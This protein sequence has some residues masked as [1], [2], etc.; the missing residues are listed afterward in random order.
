MKRLTEGDVELIFI[1]T[2]LAV[3]IFSVFSHHLDTLASI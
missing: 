2:F 1:M 3:T